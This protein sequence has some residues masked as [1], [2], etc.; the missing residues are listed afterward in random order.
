MKP[1]DDYPEGG[2]TIL[3]KLK[4]GNARREYRHWLVERDQMPCAYCGAS[5]VD[6]Y[7]HWLL[8]TV[9]HV[10]PVSG[11]DRKEGHRLG[12]CK[13]WQDSYSNIV[14]ACSGC[15]GFRNR[16]KVSWQERKESWEESEFFELRDK[17][18]REKAALIEEARN[19]EVRFYNDCVAPNDGSSKS[20]TA[21]K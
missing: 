20:N 2:Y 9:D 8:L 19:C 14:L 18:F 15:N 11:K 6:S 21:A 5:L 10:I 7:R 13:R 3:P 12:I 1:F 17:V 16:Y 4:G